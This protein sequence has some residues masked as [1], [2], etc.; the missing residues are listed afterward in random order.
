MKFEDIF[1]FFMWRVDESKVRVYVGYLGR[2]VR[3]LDLGGVE[4]ERSGWFFLRDL[5]VKIDRN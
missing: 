3:V 2:S 5:G 1:L 4:M